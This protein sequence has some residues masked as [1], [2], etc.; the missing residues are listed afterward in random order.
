MPFTCS[1]A[2]GVL[3]ARSEFTPTLPGLLELT[4]RAVSADNL[5]SSLRTAL[6]DATGAAI[7]ERPLD[8]EEMAAIA[9]LRRN[10]FELAAWNCKR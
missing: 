8:D 2:A 1:I 9:E 4:G 6:G 3:L 10:K 7:S 5:M